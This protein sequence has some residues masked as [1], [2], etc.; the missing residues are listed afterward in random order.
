MYL[1]LCGRPPFAAKTKEGT[2]EAIKHGILSFAGIFRGFYSVNIGPVWHKISE[3]AKDLI[4]SM[5]KRNPRERISIEKALKH[6]WFMNYENIVQKKDAEENLVLS[7]RNLQNFEADTTLHK[8]VL[9]YIA[10]Q[11]IASETEK[12][13]R[14]IFNT[15]DVD[16]NGVLSI[17]ELKEG[18]AKIYGSKSKAEKASKLVIEKSDVNN[19][20]CIDYNGIFLYNVYK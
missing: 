20:G 3:D 19:N 8:A 18:Y 9:S 16:K 10:S 2:V 12:K 13:L 1:L 7:L 15:L 11:E 17:S 4:K 14:E 5:L 6:P